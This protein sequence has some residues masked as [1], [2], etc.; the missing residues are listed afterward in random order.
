M[1]R[2]PTVSVVIPTYNRSD[3]ILPTVASVL[4]QTASPLEVLIVDD[5]STDDTARVCADLPEPVRYIK[6]E[7]GGVAS[8]RN[9]GI[10]E[11]RG[12]WV[13]FLDSDDTWDPEK[14]RLQLEVLEE[15]GAGWSCTDCVCVDGSDTAYEGAQ[16]FQRTFP[17]FDELGRTPVEHFR[18]ALEERRIG[19]STVFFGDAFAMLFFGNVLLPS[20]LMV[21]RDLLEKIGSFRAELRFAEETEF[22]LRVAAESPAVF[23]MRPLVRYQMGAQDA[24]TE[25]KNTGVLIDGALGALDSSILLRDTPETR[26]AYVEGRRILLIRK[27]YLHLSDLQPRKARAAL[28]EALAEGTVLEGRARKLRWLAFAPAFLL[29]LARALKRMAR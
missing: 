25:S 11:A 12:E 2:S 17:L 15:T 8:A 19:D 14:I 1:D 20:S 4:A 22:A 13:A 18:S 26:A 23:V 16:G 9:V 28:R 7:N 27:A 21:R 29:R 5:G 10:R 24:M 3:R 6:K